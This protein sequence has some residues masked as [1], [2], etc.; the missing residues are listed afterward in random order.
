MALQV[1]IKMKNK[2]P[3]IIQK[4]IKKDLLL[5]MKVLY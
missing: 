1:E 5:D 4:V 2:A 3:K